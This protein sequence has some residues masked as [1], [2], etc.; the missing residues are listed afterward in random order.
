[1]LSDVQSVFHPTDL[2]KGSEPAFAH[3]LSLALLTRSTFTILHVG[4][5]DA[6][7]SRLP[8]V[9]ETLERWGRLEPD[10]PRAAVYRELGV[11]VQK[12]R[13]RSAHPVEV[14]LEH[15]EQ[16][17]ADL[18]VL[19][20][21]GRRGMPRWL[22]RSVAEPLAQRSRTL[23]LFVPNRSR[24]FV[25][26]EDGTVSLSRVLVPWDRDPSPD[27]ALDSVADLA[28]LLGRDLEVTL[29]HVGD[30]A[31]P[32]LALP[33]DAALEW[34]ESRRSGAV[35]DEILAEAETS[36]PDLIAMATRGHEGFL[37]ALRGSTTEQ[38]LRRAPCPVLAV[39]QP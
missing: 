16:E 5:E 27:D 3:A 20:T 14:M 9:R 31:L 15:L 17:P 18:I 6:G 13:V 39:P 37:D 7:R 10:S 28:D 36:A 12:V 11:R 38:V 33:P 34:R 29:T 30:G 24:P 23:T 1:M 22:D 19:G 35:V 32:N 25:S 8:G 2:S 21:E 4:E 26:P